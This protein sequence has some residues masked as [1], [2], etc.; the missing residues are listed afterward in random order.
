MTDATTIHFVN[1]AS[2]VQR[3]EQTQL[4]VDPWISG[5][6]FDHGWSLLAPTATSPDV[7]NASTHIWVSHEHP[8]H[9]TPAFFRSIP[10]GRRRAITVLYQKTKDRKVVKFLE[11]LGF[12]TIE[13]EA[14]EWRAIGDDFEV[15]CEPVPVGDSLLIARSGGTTTVNLNDCTHLSRADL[16]KLRRHAPRLDLLFTQFGYASWQGAPEETELRKKLAKAQFD[17]ITRQ[18]AALEPKSVVP[19]ASFIWF[20]AEDNVY[21]NDANNTI[22]EAHSH[23]RKLGAQPVVMYPGDEWVVGEPHDNASALERWAARYELPE[24]R[25]KAATVPVDKLEALARDYSKRMLEFHSSFMVRALNEVRLGFFGPIH[26]YLSDHE[27]AFR[28][29][30]FEGL[31][32]TSLRR[33]QCNVT[34]ASESFAFLLEFDYGLNTLSVNGRFITNTRGFKRL[35]RAFGLGTL[36]NDGR[37]FSLEIMRDRTVWRAGARALF[38]QRRK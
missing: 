1:H 17:R 28:F 27:R 34:M 7:L 31:R 32:A 38:F 13:L 8:D 4:L 35:V 14:G 10:E 16:K 9:F 2:Y 6:A 25:H 36:K 29:S 24:P 37:R 19:F 12:E 11:R 15:L 5:D 26:V 20:S 21:L 33:D 3:Y 30:L 18:V 22:A 23:L